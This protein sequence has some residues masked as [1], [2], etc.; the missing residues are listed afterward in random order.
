MSI[1]KGQARWEGDFRNG[2]GQLTVGEGTWSGR[3]SFASRFENGA[4]TNPEELVA[5]A[6]AACFSMAFCYAL[7]QGGHEPRSIET[8]A[9]VHLRNV[10]GQPTLQKIE[11]EVEGD[12]PGIDPNRFRQYAE[13]AKA[14]CAISRALAGVEEITVSARLRAASTSS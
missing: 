6:H 11:L 12:V 5:A 10:G 3:Y 9:R 8:T 14:S 1:R 7:G 2:T 13:A 4:G